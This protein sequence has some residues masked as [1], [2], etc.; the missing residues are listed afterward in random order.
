MCGGV[1][2]FR[3]WWVLMGLETKDSATSSNT[4]DFRRL[5]GTALQIWHSWIYKSTALK[6]E[7]W[8]TLPW[9]LNKVDTVQDGDLEWMETR[10]EILGA[11]YIVGT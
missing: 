4:S 9:E 7:H 6:P 8:K 11:W 3:E 10:I 2:E 5:Q 1:H